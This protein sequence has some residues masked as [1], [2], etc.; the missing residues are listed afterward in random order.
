MKVFYS[1]PFGDTKDGR[2]KLFLLERDGVRYVPVFRSL[3]SMKAFYERMN[4][5]AYMV[6]EGDVKTVMDTNR[7]IELMRST[8][9]VIDPFCDDP[10]EIPPTA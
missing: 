8:G 1:T 9:I 10:V 4:R 2:Q 5:A 6:L 3:D 7:S